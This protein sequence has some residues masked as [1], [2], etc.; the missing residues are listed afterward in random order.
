M[1]EA[2]AFQNAIP[3]GW[4]DDPA[5]PDMERW[6][7]GTEWT[8]HVRYSNKVRPQTVEPV[9]APLAIVEVPAAEWAPRT[10]VNPALD[11]FYVPMR[12]YDPM[13]SRDLERMRQRRSARAT[14]L[15]LV[16]I[17]AIGAAVGVVL[18]VLLPR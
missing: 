17:A 16:T 9:A 2:T 7:S 8:D 11:D 15:W 4:Y 5:A 12:G 14:A 6:W 13:V 1:S 10:L 18:W 3:D